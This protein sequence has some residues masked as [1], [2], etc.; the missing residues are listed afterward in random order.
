MTIVTLATLI[1]EFDTSDLATFLPLDIKRQ[2]VHALCIEYTKSM[3]TRIRRV[4]VQSAV[5][6]LERHHL[7]EYA[8][9][10]RS[11]LAYKAR[12]SCPATIDPL[13]SM[14]FENR[15]TS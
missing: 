4:V 12:G 8:Q 6:A 9:V 10:A 1:R 5:V 3:T 7:P 15:R 11:V 2:M 13:A 14:M